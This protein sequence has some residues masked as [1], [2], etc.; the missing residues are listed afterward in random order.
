M[1]KLPDLV[2]NL[3]IVKLHFEVPN[4]KQVVMLPDNFNPEDYPKRTQQ[5][6]KNLKKLGYHLQTT[7]A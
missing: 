2:K 1:K 7:I 5:G 4:K 3:Q 6:L